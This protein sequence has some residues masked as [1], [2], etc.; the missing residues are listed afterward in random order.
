M[1]IAAI[2]S[3]SARERWRPWAEGFL[4]SLL[5]AAAAHLLYSHLGF[6]PT[7]EGYMLS[8]SRR[9]LEGQV[10]HRDYI[11]LR[12]VG[13]HI[14]HAHL[15]LWAGDRLVWWS[16][17]FPW[18]ELAA[19]AWLW[20][21][22]VAR[23]FEAFRGA[24]AR[25]SMAFIAF[26][27]SAH[28]FPM[29]PW[30]T[31]DGLFLI[32]L[33]VAL[34]RLGPERFHGLSW[35]LLGLAPLTRQSFFFPL[36]FI[37]AAFG[38]ARRPRSWAWA[39]AP[40]ALYALGILA[41]G[42]WPEAIAQARQK[43]DFIGAVFLPFLSSYGGC[44][45]PGL[46]VGGAIAG[47]S[48]L[49][50]GRPAF[51][52]AAWL[53]Q[54]GAL[55]VSI[56]TLPAFYAG[57][58]HGWF[59]LAVF[60]VAAPV[61][62]RRSPEQAR[63]A[64][65]VALNAWGASLSAGWPTPALASGPVLLVLGAWTLDGPDGFAAEAARSRLRTIVLPL[66]L[67]VLAAVQ[68]HA[69]RLHH[70]YRDGDA[71]ELTHDLGAVLRGAHGI[72]TNAL[73]YTYMK[74]L[75]EAVRWAEERSAGRSIVMMPDAPQFWV[76]YPGTNPLSCDWPAN[77]ELLMP[78]NRERLLG[79]IRARRGRSLFVVARTRSDLFELNQVY[80]LTDEECATCAEVRRN[81]TLIHR[82]D[83]FDVYE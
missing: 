8:G 80:A 50:R 83:F 59:S 69:G 57:S 18:L 78:H 35:F 6:N 56:I 20:T 34:R 65:L 23:P 66:A 52:R 3:G 58:M 31:I 47:L 16:R 75:D 7:D 14:L 2:D 61:L 10:P 49:A 76:S 38:D 64:A 33:A 15:L 39:F 74:S 51:L 44:V 73:T 81:G 1:E 25:A 41:A 42:A 60:A 36:P 27:A 13:T 53:L 40:S 29:M 32:S 72:R 45:E 30:N 12:P 22:V 67:A 37:L 26:A 11:S 79:E 70:I 21:I 19:S 48:W 77:D 68:F 82:N 28:T 43:G 62:V 24:V 63:V 17:F 71:S 54:A 46:A 9:L 55:C 4:F 5:V